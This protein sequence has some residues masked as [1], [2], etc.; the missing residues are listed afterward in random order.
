M[1]FYFYPLSWIFLPQRIEFLGSD[2]GNHW[3]SLEVFTPENPEI[4]AT[5]S[6]KT[7]T[8]TT[9]ERVRYVRV[10]AEPRPEIPA[11]HRA[12]GEKL[13]IFTDEIIVK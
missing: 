12:A 1:D 11:W 8:A 3:Q 2:D 4:L 7:F 10:V 9:K 5:P 13:W 6:I